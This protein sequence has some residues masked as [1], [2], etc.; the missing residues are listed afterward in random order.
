MLLPAL[1]QAVPRNLST[2]PA[3]S[4]EF[5]VF[6]NYYLIAANFKHR[7]QFYKEID[8]YQTADSM[9]ND[10]FRVRPFYLDLYP[11][12]VEFQPDSYGS[13]LQWINK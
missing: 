7:L 13:M 3:E 8:V 4:I 6:V 10:Y 2:C 12:T 1:D 9:H 11:C 5:K